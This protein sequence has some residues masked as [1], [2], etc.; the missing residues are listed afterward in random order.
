MVH[1]LLL[2]N[3]KLNMPVFLMQLPCYYFTVYKEI[4]LTKDTNSSK[5]YY[6]TPF[7]EIVGNWKVQKGI[8][9]NGICSPQIL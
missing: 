3:K 6:H 4:T 2:S 8:V 1:Q 9:S 5:I 7:Q